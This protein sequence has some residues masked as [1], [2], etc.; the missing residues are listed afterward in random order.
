MPYRFFCGVFVY[1]AVGVLYNYNKNK[2]T[3]TEMLPNYAF[4]VAIPGLVKVT[5]KNAST[6]AC[7]QDLCVHGFTAFLST[8][9]N[10]LN[11]LFFTSHPLF[12]RFISLS[13]FNVRSFYFLLQYLVKFKRNFIK[14]LTFFHLIFFHRLFPSVIILVV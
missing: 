13:Y 2:A 4:W 5:Q 3:G 1:I 8:W 6:L 12:Y 14:C 9:F 10:P 7:N 11:L